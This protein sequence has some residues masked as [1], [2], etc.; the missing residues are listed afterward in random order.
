M[1]VVFPPGFSTDRNNA[2]LRTRVPA[3]LIESASYC[4]R[5]DELINLQRTPHPTS[6][7]GVLSWLRG[8]KAT[9]ENLTRSVVIYVY[10]GDDTNSAITRELPAPHYGYRINDEG[11][12]GR[13]VV[14]IGCF[15]V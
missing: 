9:S 7:T 2:Y 8:I 1:F 14:F 5:K 10:S 12:R 6:L 4:S 15:S 13:C 3:C 11:A